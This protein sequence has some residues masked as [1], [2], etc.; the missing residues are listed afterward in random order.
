MSTAYRIPGQ[1]NYLPG[2][3]SSALK[4]LLKSLAILTL[5]LEVQDPCAGLL[6]DALIPEARDFFI[7][8][9]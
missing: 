4:C 3:A 5:R 7:L 2:P 1:P 9:G 8:G 6:I